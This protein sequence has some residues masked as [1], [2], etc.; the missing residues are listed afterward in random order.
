MMMRESIP[1][2]RW[3]EGLDRHFWEIL[4]VLGLIFYARCAY[5]DLAPDDILWYQGRAATVFDE[6]RVVP[7]LCFRAL[8][9]VFGRSILAAQGMIFTFH[10]LNAILVYHLGHRLLSSV[11]AGRLAATV[12]FINPVTLGALTWISCFSYI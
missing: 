6:Y 10:T 2:R 7:L 8:N 11:A 12:F 3:I 9:F 5:S 4:F 1:Y